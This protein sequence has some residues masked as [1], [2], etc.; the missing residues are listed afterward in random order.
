VFDPRIARVLD[1][2]TGT[3]FE[4][5]LHA[6]PHV[7]SICSGGR[8]DDL[9]GLFT[10][11]RLP[12]VGGSIGVSRILAALA[13]PAGEARPSRRSL[14]VITRHEE[15]LAETLAMAADL[16]LRIDSAVEVYPS[17]AKHATQMKYA[18][19]RGARFVL[20]I[21]ADGSVSVKDMVSGDRH[22]CAQDAAAIADQLAKLT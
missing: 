7:G 15:N 9:A 4:T 17:P 19:A 2:Y 13:D 20:T 16:R 18:D 22:T 14:V 6:A 11:A 10:T 8:Y 12:G 3:V 1:C 21:D 5:T